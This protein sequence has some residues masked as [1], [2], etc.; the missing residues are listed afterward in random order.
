MRDKSKL[1]GSA[2]GHIIRP[3]TARTPFA[4]TVM[5]LATKLANVSSPCTVV[6][7]R[8]SSIWHVSKFSWQNAGP[9]QASK[10]ATTPEDSLEDLSDDVPLNEAVDSVE[11]ADE[12]QSMAEAS[13]PSASPI[14]EVS[15]MMPVPGDSPAPEGD[16]T[17]TVDSALNPSVLT[18]PPSTQEQPG[19]RV[20][21][22]GFIVESNQKVVASVPDTEIQPT[23]QS[24]VSSWAEIVN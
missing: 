16:F 17:E 10:P 20:N 23:P 1:V 11:E 12:K 4:L 14:L 24:D 5:V 3:Q 8:A 7:V 15:Q 6:F 2:I 13:S 9:K 22:D 21:E 18:V 19:P